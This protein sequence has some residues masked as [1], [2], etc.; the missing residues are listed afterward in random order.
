MMD[1]TP[2]PYSVWTYMDDD[3][4]LTQS[5]GVPDIMVAYGLTLPNAHMARERIELIAGDRVG[6][7]EIRDARNQVLTTRGIPTPGGALTV[8]I[9]DYGP[10]PA[11]RTDKPKRRTLSTREN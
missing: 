3:E 4:W 10:R 8:T 5:G 2:P 9:T 6:A 1:P 11:R 7:V